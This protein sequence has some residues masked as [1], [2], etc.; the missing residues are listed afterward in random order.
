MRIIQL[1][2]AVCV[3]CLGL[4]MD[5]VAQ[6]DWPTTRF[7][8]C[9]EDPDSYLIDY[10]PGICDGDPMLAVKI[11]SY[12]QE[13]A[14]DLRARGFRAP[15]LGDTVVTSDGPAYPVFVFNASDDRDHAA[16]NNPCAGAEPYFCLDLK[17]SDGAAV[18]S[19]NEI[20]DKGYADM[21]H[22]L[23]HAV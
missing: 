11:E 17:R 19:E 3:A 22:E 13:V 1:L 14:E 23:F 2:G 9:F 7:K 16:H 15:T 4:A 18:F 6:T 12:L 10:R 5:A 8:V 21:A 20:T